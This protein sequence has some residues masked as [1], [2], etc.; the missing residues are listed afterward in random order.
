MSLTSMGRGLST[1]LLVGIVIVAVVLVVA[2]LYLVP[3]LT[4]PKPA[5]SPPPTPTPVTTSNTSTTKPTP[6]PTP[7]QEVA[8]NN[9]LALMT[10]EYTA[11]YSITVNASL[12]ATA[13]GMTLSFPV[14]YLN[15][16]RMEISWSNTTGQF[17]LYFNGL[18]T[19]NYTRNLF[20]PPEQMTT[21]LVFAAYRNGS[22]VC[23]ATGQP[24]AN[25]S[26]GVPL[27]YTSVLTCNPLPNNTAVLHVFKDVLINSIIGNLTYTGNTT[28]GG[29]AAYCFATSQPVTINVT[30]VL[31]TLLN[32][33]T[34]AMNVTGYLVVNI[35]NMCLLENGIVTNLGGTVVL[36]LQSQNATA[37]IPVDFTLN[38]LNYT[39]SFDNQGFNNLLRNPY[40][41]PSTNTTNTTT[42]TTV[43]MN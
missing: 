21:Y 3:T 19:M 1:S 29:E 30:Q 25:Q 35:T 31:P 37:M 34:T 33:N 41:V 15:T 12:I 20:A 24:L 40:I 9:T 22:Q 42:T 17:E 23:T 4:R 10:G 18:I 28:W 14:L 11:W 38:L 5:P 39:M 32:T 2:V 16:T 8:L 36:V 43:A 26:M 13:Q 7:P 27:N 6:P